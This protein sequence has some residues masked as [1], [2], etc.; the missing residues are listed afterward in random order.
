MGFTILVLQLLAPMC[1]RIVKRYCGQTVRCYQ[2]LWCSSILNF[3]AESYSEHGVKKV[4]I[5][6]TT[7]RSY[8]PNIELSATC[9]RIVFKRCN[10]S[11][12]VS[13]LSLSPTVRAFD[14]NTAAPASAARQD[15]TSHYT[16]KASR[17][18]RAPL[19]PRLPALNQITS[20]HHGLSAKRCATVGTVLLLNGAYVI[21]DLEDKA[22]RLPVQGAA[23]AHVGKTVIADIAQVS[24]GG[25]VATILTALRSPTSAQTKVY[26][27]AARNG[28]S[29][30]FSPAALAE[31]AQIAAANVNPQGI[32]LTAMPFVT[33]DNK[34]TT[35]L[36]QAVYIEAHADGYIV[37]YALADAKALLTNPTGALEREARKRCASIYLPC[38]APQGL[39]E[40]LGV[41][42]PE[43]AEDVGSLN[44]DKV[45]RALVVS[46]S[47]N[48]KGEVLSSQF[49]RAIVK[50]QA[51]LNFPEVQEYHRAGQNFQGPLAGKT[52]SQSLKLLAVVGKLRMALAAQRGVVRHELPERMVV[53]VPGTDNTLA[54]VTHVGLEIEKWNEQI[55]LLVNQLTGEKIAA[56]RVNGQPLGAIYRVQPEP[57]A[58]QLERLH[59]QL[60]ALQVPWTSGSLAEYLDILA[61]VV[62][63]AA[64][65]TDF[66]ANEK[67]ELTSVLQA[68]RLLVLRTQ[69]RAEFSTEALGHSALVMPHYI[70]VTAWLRRMTDI[71]AHMDLAYLEE[72]G[73]PPY[74]NSPLLAEFIASSAKHD[75]MDRRI[76]REVQEC[77]TARFLQ[78]Y[79][80][81]D[82]P[83]TI[84]DLHCHGNP[85]QWGVSLEL[86]DPAVRVTMLLKDLGLAHGAVVEGEGAILKCGNRTFKLGGRVVAHIAKFDAATDHITVTLSGQ[87][88]PQGLDAAAAQL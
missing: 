15:L 72:G 5:I 67:R 63:R 78:T 76:Q 73:A 14:F 10:V 7:F 64:G 53:V 6:L 13:A 54:V 55:S 45:R 38:D 37:H 39:G 48:S 66:A 52:Y 23:Q 17:H 27:I 74:Q 46:V 49:R 41:F 84:M 19:S 8:A 59:K 1:W 34:S 80:G 42:P 31:V 88:L 4:D 65:M 62:N 71:V 82:L 70:Q 81:R 60:E 58:E 61:E 51:K 3:V 56:A 21:Q 44:P 25:R 77:L 30:G 35:V 18:D 36:D 26:A 43:L 33:I 22:L 2:T 9:P 11:S 85:A 68:I 50:S 16:Y 83:G 86:D 29:F 28:A 20:P 47:L 75:D 32:D 40:S 69:K 57:S 12:R 24:G 79:V 87:T